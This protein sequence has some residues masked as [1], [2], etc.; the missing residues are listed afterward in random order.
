MSISITTEGR[1]TSGAERASPGVVVKWLVVISRG[2][3]VISKLGSHFTDA[4]TFRSE[5]KSKTKG[6]RILL[7]FSEVPTSARTSGSVK[8]QTSD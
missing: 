7:N 5:A 4:V 3:R 1:A 2:L 8:Y 6:G